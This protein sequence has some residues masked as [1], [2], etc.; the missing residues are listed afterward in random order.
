MCFLFESASAQ[1]CLT[2]SQ[3]FFTL[4]LSPLACSLGINIYIRTSVNFETMS[5]VKLA[6]Q[7]KILTWILATTYI[8]CHLHLVFRTKLFCFPVHQTARGRMS[9]QKSNHQQPS[10]TPSNKSLWEELK[11]SKKDGVAVQNVFSLRGTVYLKVL[12]FPNWDM[13]VNLYFGVWIRS[14]LVILLAG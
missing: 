6:I 1:I 8:T 13:Y 10:S 11:L 4:P 9:E 7:I 12:V 3:G 14:N 5:T 2:L